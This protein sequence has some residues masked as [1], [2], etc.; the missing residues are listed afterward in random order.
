MGILSHREN[1]VAK[2]DKATGKIVLV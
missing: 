2:Y 1:K